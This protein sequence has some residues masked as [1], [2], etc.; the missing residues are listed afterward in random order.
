[1]TPSYK[2]PG[3]R[4]RVIIFKEMTTLAG[5]IAVVT[6]GTAGVGSGIASEL[7]KFGARVFVTGRSIQDGARNGSEVIGIRC[8]H[9]EDEQVASAFERVT[10]EAGAV[11]IL[12]NNV[13]GGYEQ[14]MEDGAGKCS[15]SS[16]DT[17]PERS[18]GKDVASGERGAGKG[19]VALVPASAHRD[20]EAR[21]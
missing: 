8:D 7:A 12:L 17:C 6:G 21:F 13:W 11:D 18:G 9:R 3:G 15:P 2:I 14:M 16:R 4:K 10:Q 1:V 19:A 20:P 5:R